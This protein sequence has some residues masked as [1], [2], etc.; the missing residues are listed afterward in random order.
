MKTTEVSTAKQFTVNDVPL[1]LKQ[2]KEQ[3]SE[4]RKNIP[5]SLPQTG[6]LDGFGKIENIKTLDLLIKA[7]SSVRKKVEAYNEEV[8]LIKAFVGSQVKLPS[9]KLNGHS[10]KTWLEVIDSQIIVIGNETELKKL[11]EI[12]KT[13]EDNLSAEAKLANDLARIQGI[14]VNTDSDSE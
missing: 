2:V 4:I 8:A 3:I 5:Q 14:L 10:E 11:Q 9:C 12:Q 1:L 7:R 6:E 13:L